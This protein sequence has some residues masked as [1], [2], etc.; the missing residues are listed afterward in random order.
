[1]EGWISLHRKL[2]Y[3]WMWTEK[4]EFS[5]AEAWIDILLQ[6]N[7]KDGQVIIKNK[8]YEVK[9]GDSL[10]SLET[11]AKRWRWTRNRV[12]RFLELLKNDGMIRFECDSKTT[13]LTV[14]NYDSYQSERT[15]NV[16][17]MDI[18]RTSNV[19]QTYTNNN[20]NNDNNDN[21]LKIEASQIGKFKSDLMSEVQQTNII[22]K[23]KFKVEERGGLW[24]CDYNFNP[25]S[26]LTKKYNSFQFICKRFNWKFNDVN[27]MKNSFFNFVVNYWEFNTET[28]ESKIKQQ[29]KNKYA[30]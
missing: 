19:H 6:V 29:F 23:A 27:H 9:R 18:K 25:Y 10:N 5:K 2:Q 20:D 15:L 7:H 24:A 22:Q 3:N 13:H 4:R 30:R 8:L 26:Q 1:M 16:H 28:I 17:Q 12:K 21:K 11:W 14:C